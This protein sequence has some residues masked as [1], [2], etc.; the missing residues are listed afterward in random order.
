VILCFGLMRPYKGIDVLLE[1]FREVDGAELWIVGMPRM[2]IE[3]L[4]ELAARAPGTVRFVPRLIPDGEI[5]AYFR[6]ADIVVLPYR[7]I[8]QSGVLYTA[9]PFGTPLVLSSVGGFTEVAEEHGAARLV[10]PGDAAELAGA[11]NELIA[12]DAE[13]TRLGQ[14]AARAAAT[15]YSWDDVARRHVELYRELLAA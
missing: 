7:Q 4:R 3:P 13:R 14:A 9:L 15:H 11:L 2:P 1:A 5:P 8:D 10:A 6:R 12:D